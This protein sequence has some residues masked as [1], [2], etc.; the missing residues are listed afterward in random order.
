MRDWPQQTQPSPHVWKG[1]RRTIE[2]RLDMMPH[3]GTRVTR[4]DGAEGPWTTALV[5]EGGRG[6]EEGVG[7]GWV[8]FSVEM[9]RRHI[10]NDC[11]PTAHDRV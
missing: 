6:G 1:S 11:P 3:K 10:I 9:P 2:Q 8:V 7:H 5:A 4:V